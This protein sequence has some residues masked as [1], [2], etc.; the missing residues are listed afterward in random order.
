MDITMGLKSIAGSS[1]KFVGR[2]VGRSVDWV[3]VNAANAWR[4]LLK[5]RIPDY[6]VLTLDRDLSELAGDRPWWLHYV[7][8]F[9]DELSLEGLA[10]VL[11]RIAGDP[12]VRGI[13]FLLKGTELTLSQAQNLVALLA[14][15]RAWD[16]E[17]HGAARKEIVV[18]AETVSGPSALMLGVADR[19]I[20]P[21]LASWD[22]VGLQV[23]STFLKEPLARVGI[24]VEVARVAPWK[25][26]ADAV[27]RNEM[28]EAQREQLNWLLD[29]LHGTLV[30]GI[31]QGRALEEAVVAGLID[32]GPLT[33]EDALAAGLIDRIA[34][35]DELPGVLGEREVE[36]EAEGEVT[37]G[38]FGQTER[39]LK[40]H[41]APAAAGRIGVIRLEGAIMPGRSR[42]FPMPLPLLGDNLIGSTTA[43]QQ[44]RA[45]RRDTDLKAVV[46][47][48]DSPGGSA[49]ASDLIWRELKLLDEEKPVVIYMGPVAASGGY[50]IATPGRKIVAQSA[51]LTG[52][53]GVIV[54]KA[55]T[56]AL[57][58]KVGAT[59][60]VIRRG[61]NAGIY[62]SDEP[63]SP[64]QRALVD[65][66]LD[67]TYRAFKERVAAGRGLDFDALEPLCG[68]RVWTGQQALER[69]LVDAIGD[70]QTA[71]DLAKELAG[72][73]ADARVETVHIT[74]EKRTVL[75]MPGKE[76]LEEVQDAAAFT[77]E[78]LDGSLLKLLATEQV[79]LLADNVAAIPDTAN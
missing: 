15:F 63:W 41:L 37:L 16:G 39:L 27:S 65:E 4:M 13:V 45:A 49:L 3:G 60:E 55:V 32:R 52:S 20:L 34:Y 72:I 64:T 5:G 22:V 1:V 2:T 19:A 8:G 26:A 14:R 53:I 35:E 31:S 67:Y 70:F 10:A 77:R 21:P 61:E 42:N 17:Y 47:Y 46:V 11:R 33:A 51:T 69:G 7:P 30:Q 23:T 12:D 29:S 24:D 25:T 79:W 44:I 9:G 36:V 58:A 43:Q 56:Q 28:S 48:V 6:I 50:Y 78:L 40:H 68:G 57:V 38:S 59:T 76:T 74:P 73:R 75:P 62:R 18:Y 71:V 66:Q 54:A